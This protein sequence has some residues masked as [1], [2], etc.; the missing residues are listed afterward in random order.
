M[1]PANV[2]IRDATPGTDDDDVVRLMT[3]YMTWAHQRLADDFGIA[4]P[5]ADPDEIRDHLDE[6]RPPQGR[7]LLAQC[8]GEPAGVGALRMLG[9]DVAEIKRMYVA[10][11]WR[12]QHL[13]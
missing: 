3:D 8:A 1:L 9:D 5:P 7:L 6:Y 12:D 10:P 4:E 13:G 2:L 11:E